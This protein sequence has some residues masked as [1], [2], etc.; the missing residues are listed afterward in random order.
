MTGAIFM[1]SIFPGDSFPRGNF[2]GVRFPGAFFRTPTVSNLLLLKQSLPVD[3][4]SING[5]SNRPL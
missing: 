1:G 3:C 2:S 5:L 4:L